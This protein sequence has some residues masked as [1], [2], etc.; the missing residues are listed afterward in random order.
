MLFARAARLPREAPVASPESPPPRDALSRHYCPVSSASRLRFEL[1]PSCGAG[2]C[3]IFSI[4]SMRLPRRWRAR[5][6]SARFFW[7]TFYYLR[8]SEYF[9][10]LGAAY[11]YFFRRLPFLPRRPV[12]CGAHR[13]RRHTRFSP[14]RARLRTPALSLLAEVAEM[15]VGSST[16][17]G[18]AG[19]LPEDA[20]CCWVSVMQADLFAGVICCSTPHEICAASDFPFA[21]AARAAGATT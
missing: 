6:A 4:I 9:S 1:R 17:A 19:G 10:T 2:D 12:R 3:S 18:G 15:P 5:L 16:V 8:P 7:L 13:P 11:L 21:S 14:P 20:D